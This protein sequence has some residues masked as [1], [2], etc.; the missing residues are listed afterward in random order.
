MNA[1]PFSFIPS[2]NRITTC[3]I[4]PRSQASDHATEMS[5]TTADQR[6]APQPATSNLLEELRRT[7]AQA[8]ELAGRLEGE[9]P[10]GARAAGEYELLREENHALA[11]QLIELERRNHRM[12]NLYVA[13]Y[14]LYHGR[15]PET[16][17]QV[18]AEIVTDLMGAE[19]FVL[20]LRSTGEG[21]CR[22]ALR[23]GLD[24]D[25]AETYGAEL[26]VGGD[27]H[28]DAALAWGER[29]F[30]PAGKPLVVVPL[31]VGGVTL[32]ALVVLALLRHKNSFTSSDSEI[33]DLLAAHA[34]SALMASDT[35]AAVARKLQ[36]LESLMKLAR[37]E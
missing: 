32:G 4:S 31:Q 33:I 13:T 22:V 1:A 9:A 24:G 18:I 29:H 2:F 5:A 27:P 23:R 19:Q 34:A 6:P 35:Y 21:P 28:V 3:G 26:Y 10:L 7:L 14:Q 8:D 37:G 17:T 36:T 30:D 11:A 12:L 16:V 15:S 25:N 20:L